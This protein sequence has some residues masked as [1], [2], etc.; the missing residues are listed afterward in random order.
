MCLCATWLETSFGIVEPVCYLQ[1]LPKSWPWDSQEKITASDQLRSTRSTRWRNHPRPFSPVNCEKSLIFFKVTKVAGFCPYMLNDNKKAKDLIGKAFS[2]PRNKPIERALKFS[3]LLLFLF[4]RS[5]STK[6]QRCVVY[7]R[8]SSSH[9]KADQTGT[10]TRT[11]CTPSSVPHSSSHSCGVSVVIWSRLPWMH[12]THLPG[13]CSPT[14]T[15]LR[16]SSYIQTTRYFL[17]SVCLFVRFFSLAIEITI[18]Y[19]WYK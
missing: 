12:L 17:L 14:Q 3:L 2:R 11:S 16:W 15:M 9:R 13:I 6:W 1:E 8:A 19:W 5:T 18:M 4:S 10:W 7:W